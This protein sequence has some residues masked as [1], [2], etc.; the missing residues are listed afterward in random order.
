MDTKELLKKL[1]E[2]GKREAEA[3]KKG[4][5]DYIIVSSELKEQLDKIQKEQENK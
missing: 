5:V 2:F 4:G 1:Q 3:R